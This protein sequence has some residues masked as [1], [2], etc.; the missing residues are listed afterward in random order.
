MRTS[1]CFVTAVLCLF[2]CLCQAQD[3]EPDIRA[4]LQ[5]L[6][7][8]LD[9][10]DRE[11]Q[12]DKRV[13]RIGSTRRVVQV[14]EGMVVRIYDASDLF[15]VAPSYIAKHDSDV[16]G[17]RQPFFPIAS[18]IGVSGVG[19]GGGGF[20]GGGGVFNLDS[21]QR[22]IHAPTVKTLHQFDGT[23]AMAAPID[24]RSARVSL[25]DLVGAITTTISPD[26]WSDVGGEGSISTIGSS[27]LISQTEA[28][29]EQISSLMNLFRERWG[30]LRTVSVIA[31]WIWLKEPELNELLAKNAEAYGLVDQD[32]WLHFRAAPPAADRRMGYSAAITCQNGQTVHTLAGGQTVAV[33]NLT[34]VV[35]GAQESVGYQPSISLIQEG[36]ALQVTPISNRSGKFVTIDVHSRV[37]LLKGVERKPQPKPQ[38]WQ[39]QPELDA[40]VS[41]IDR[42][43]VSTQRLSTTL[44]MP[45]GKPMLVGGMTFEGQPTAQ[46]PNLYL[47][48]T[49]AIQELRDDLE[50][51][52]AEPDARPD[53]APNAGAEKPE[54]GG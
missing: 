50:E 16:A 47:F 44:R 54:V 12:G 34:P 1:I 14:E 42:P 32:R 23:E 38:P 2:P 51:A 26:S 35:G 22:Q 28:I 8:Q 18:T 7:S 25:D 13:T 3:S 33:T 36:A 40:V 15:V 29:H 48:V 19:A 9:S 41:A 6:Q 17:N 45:V 43:E 37:T 49:V 52:K 5:T 31:D 46:D 39:G 24:L 10:R 20:G 27:L 11:D 21:S 53:A 30:S 4:L